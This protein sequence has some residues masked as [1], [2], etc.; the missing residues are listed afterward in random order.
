[1]L[2]SGGPEEGFGLVT[3]ITGAMEACR[4]SRLTCTDTFLSGLVLPGKQHSDSSQACGVRSDQNVRRRCP[5]V[6]S[7]S[8]VSW[9]SHRL[10]DSLPH[11]TVPSFCK[12]L[13]REAR[14]RYPRR[15][16]LV[17]EEL[18]ETENNAAAEEAADVD[19]DSNTNDEY[20]E[21]GVVVGTHGIKGEVVIRSLTDF[22]K[23]RFGTPGVRWFRRPG[24]RQQALIEV[25]LLKGRRGPSRKGKD[26]SILLK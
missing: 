16:A 15:G 12:F 11:Q 1:M 8:I 21:I 26:E 17:N 7:K 14:S 19:E 22:P 5:P 9:Q 23:K 24:R 10:R 13:H 3:S 20:V 18:A 25:E 6:T 4:A 2:S